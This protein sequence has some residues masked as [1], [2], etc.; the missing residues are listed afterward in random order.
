[1][2]KLFSLERFALHYDAPT[3]YRRIVGAAIKIALA[4][5]KAIKKPI[6]ERLYKLSVT[7]KVWERAMFLI[8]VKPSSICQMLFPRDMFQ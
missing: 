8:Q 1:M 7:T 3:F 5:I 4:D 6:I 2:S